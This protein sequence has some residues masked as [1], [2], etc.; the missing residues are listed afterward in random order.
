MSDK[1]YIT[2]SIGEGTSEFWLCGEHDHDIISKIQAVQDACVAEHHPSP[3]VGQGEP[4]PDTESWV[5]MANYLMRSEHSRQDLW[6]AVLGSGWETWG[7]WEDAVYSKGADWD[8]IG[9]ITLTI[10]NP[11]DEDSKPISKML[12]VDDLAAA[13]AKS[14]SRGYRDSCT[15][16]RIDLDVQGGFDACSSDVVL[17]IAV[18]GDVVYG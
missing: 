16:E 18:L 4:A 12:G 6:E 13:L 11:D 5:G 15:G 9:T 14:I 10:A 2:V 1:V 3:T 17:Q 8:S 7:W